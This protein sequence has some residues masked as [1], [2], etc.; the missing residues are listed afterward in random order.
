M[1]SFFSSPARPAY[2]PRPVPL[3]Q[4]AMTPEERVQEA[5]R[6]NDSYYNGGKSK[7][8]SRKHKSKTHRRRR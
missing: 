1:G 6:K 5:Y 4:R 7:K 3:M 8:H 2:V